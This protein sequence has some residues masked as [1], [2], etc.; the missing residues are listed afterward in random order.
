M[1][2]KIFFSLAIISSLIIFFVLFKGLQNTNIYTPQVD[3]KKDIP[4]FEAKLF[5]S[6]LVKNSKE[7][8]QKEKFYLLNIWASWCAPCRDE[9]PILLKLKDQ[10]NLEIIGLNYKDNIINAK[11]FLKELNSPY[12]LIL[13]DENGIIA[14][15]WGAYGVPET[16]LIY[17]KRI[18]KRYVGPLNMN[19]IIEIKKFIE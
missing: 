19:S 13:L 17:N 4:Y 1:K 2:T 16:F 12:K 6:D 8:F 18:V 11:K 9:H 15:E 14:I 7:I 5:D 10:V 3:V